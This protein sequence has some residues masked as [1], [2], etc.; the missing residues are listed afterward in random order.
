MSFLSFGGGY[1]GTT[2]WLLDGG[3]NVAAGWGGS[4]YVPAVDDIQEFKVTNNSFSAEY[5]WSTGNVVNMVTKSGTS[6][7]HI[8]MDEYIRNPKLDAN[9]YFNNMASC[10]HGQATIAISSESPAAVRCIFRAFTSN[11]TRPSFS[12]IMRACGST[13]PAPLARLQYAHFRPGGGRLFGDSRRH[14]DCRCNG[15]RGQPSLCR[16]DLQSLH[17][18][19]IHHWSVRGKLRSLTLSRKQN[20]HERGRG[21]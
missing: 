15:L 14:R 12:P 5:G 8:V 7:F 9:T 10:S 18:D 21:D 4:I 6:D 3:W 2:A 16:R 13:I 17:H 1:F 19:V 20:T 11:A